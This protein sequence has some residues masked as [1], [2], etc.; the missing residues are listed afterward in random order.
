MGSNFLL[1]WGTINQAFAAGQIGMYIVGLRRLQQPR[2]RERNRPDDYGLTVI[3]LE[4][5][6]AGVLGGGDI[7]AVRPDATTTPSATPP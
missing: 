6:D 5:D 4:G 3:P 2:D 1:D 7:A